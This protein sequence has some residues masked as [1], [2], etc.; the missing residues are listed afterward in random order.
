MHAIGELDCDPRTRL[1]GLFERQWQILQGNIHLIASACYPFQSVLDALSQ[2]SSALPAE[3]MTGAR[4]LPGSEVMDR[5]EMEG[6]RLVLD[7]FGSPEQYRVTLQPHSGTQ[8]NQIVYNAVL[9]PKDVVLSLQTKDGGHVSHTVLIGRRNETVHYT[10]TD[11]GII[12][13]DRLREIA[14]SSLP[15]LIIIGGSALPRQIDFRLC[16]D[17]AK[18]CG[19]YLHA[20]MSHTAAFIAAG[21]HQPVFPY[22]DFA[23]FNPVKNLRGPNGGL[24][25]YRDVF[26]RDIQT[27]IFP[28][29]Q[30]GANENTM[31]G[32]FATFLEWKKRDLTAHTRRILE[33]SEIMAAT[34]RDHDIKMTTGGTDCHLLLLEF[35]DRTETGADLE[36]KFQ[37]L[38]VLANRNLIPNDKR[39]PL[40]TSGLRICTTNLAILKYEPDDTAA[41]ASWIAAHINGR[42]ASDDLIPALLQKYQ[43]R[44]EQILG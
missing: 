24:L 31:F 9:S 27:A 18:E 20:D 43:S 38:G 13:Y 14:L 2:P 4:Y 17:I 22:C 44:R 8:A 23:A 30:G 40:V 26:S 34:F 6:E 41:L 15:R 28:T 37:S 16:G 33:Q 21:L 29:T 1:L 19:A 35:P 3:G 32:K 10:L 5:V 36:K 39:P 11:D 42:P 7:L 12:D 25:I